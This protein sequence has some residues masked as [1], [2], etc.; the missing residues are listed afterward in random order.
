MRGSAQNTLG[1]ITC[2]PLNSEFHVI[3]E[4]EGSHR[5]LEP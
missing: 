4:G 5:G 2:I 3:C 1:A